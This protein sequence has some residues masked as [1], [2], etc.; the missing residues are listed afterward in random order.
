MRGVG[1][2]I[3]IIVTK[4]YGRYEGGMG[5]VFNFQKNTG[6][7]KSYLNGE[8]TILQGD[9]VLLFVQWNTFWD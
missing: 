9:I 2:G 5:G 3:Q 6:L 7:R 4:V 1:V 8:V